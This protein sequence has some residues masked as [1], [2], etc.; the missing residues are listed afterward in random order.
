FRGGANRAEQQAQLARLK[1]EVRACRRAVEEG[2]AAYSLIL[3]PVL[4]ELDNYPFGEVHEAVRLFALE[5]ELPYLDLL[6][7]FAGR[8]A[9]E[10]RVSIANEHPNPEGHRIAALSITQHLRGNLLPLFNARP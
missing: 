5:E 3:F 9:V 1:A 6:D 8:D 10:L 4:A 2:G 7:V